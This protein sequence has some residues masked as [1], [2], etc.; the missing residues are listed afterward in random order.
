MGHRRMELIVKGFPSEI[1]STTHLPPIYLVC[2]QHKV[3][4]LPGFG[5]CETAS[6]ARGKKFKKL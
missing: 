2:S 4:V 3:L 5:D 6:L 1:S